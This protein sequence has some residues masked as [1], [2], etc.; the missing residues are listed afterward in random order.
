VTIGICGK[1][2]HGKTT[3]AATLEDYFAQRQ[4][5]GVFTISISD[6]VMEDVY[7]AGLIPQETPRENLTPEQLAFLV[8]TGKRRRREDPDYWL[9]KMSKYV[10]EA[11][12]EVLLVP[13]VRFPNEVA[14][15]QAMNGIML[16]I[17]RIDD[18]GKPFVSPDR[19]PNDETETSLDGYKADYSISATCTPWLIDAVSHFAHG[20]FE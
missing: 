13:N 15:V 7:A 9:D 11:R 18:N 5:P 19:D 4:W 3:A 14:W 17:V 16:R 1:A 12:P 8:E 2:R 10:F 20:E 6:Y